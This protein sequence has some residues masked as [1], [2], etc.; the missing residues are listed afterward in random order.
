MDLEFLIVVLVLLV[1]ILIF[2]RRKNILGEFLLG[3]GFGALWEFITRNMLLDPGRVSIN[4]I[5][6]I[7]WG[8]VFVSTTYYAEVI[9]KEWGF[10]SYFYPD[11]I[12]AIW[13]LGIELV[14]AKVMA[15]WEY[16]PELS[17]DTVPILGLPT[18]VL[19]AWPVLVIV[20]NN[21]IRMLDPIIEGWAARK[22]NIKMQLK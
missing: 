12:S 20:Y 7:A 5:V 4:L 3:M 15:G 14:G 22:H 2:M 11:L 18:L 13:G 10:R 21:L 9:K 1:P 17:G 16:S 8:I 19:I 6:I